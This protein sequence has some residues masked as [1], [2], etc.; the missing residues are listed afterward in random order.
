MTTEEL[1]NVKPKLTACPPC[2]LRQGHA[3]GLVTG[4]PPLGVVAAAFRK[5]LVQWPLSLSQSEDSPER[6]TRCG[7]QA[8][9]VLSQQGE[10]KSGLR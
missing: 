7:A 2:Q 3:Q 6:D 4:G 1:K 10:K 9:S 8:L 5:E